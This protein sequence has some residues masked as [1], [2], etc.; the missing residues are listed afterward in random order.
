MSQHEIKTCPRCKS[1]FECKVGSVLQCQCQAVTLTAEHHAYI[2]ERYTDC[3]CVTCLS[4]L[5]SECNQAMHEARIA[6]V[7][8][9]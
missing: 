5:R 7:I 8:V 2:A 3:L 9:R 6:E 1:E 4:Q